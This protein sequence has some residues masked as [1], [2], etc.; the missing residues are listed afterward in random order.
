MFVGKRLAHLSSNL[1][2]AFQTLFLFQFRLLWKCWTNTEPSVAL[3]LVRQSLDK[4]QNGPV[5]FSAI[6]VVNLGTAELL[7][8]TLITRDVNIVIFSENYMDFRFAPFYKLC[9]CFL[10][11]IIL[12]LKS[13]SIPPCKSNYTKKDFS[14]AASAESNTTLDKARPLWLQG[15]RHQSGFPAD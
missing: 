10:F 12:F 1:S 14:N 15:I 9:G 2:T 4:K 6:S 11:L 8:L 3:L 7:R 5:R 13:L